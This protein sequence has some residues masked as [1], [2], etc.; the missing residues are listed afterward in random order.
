[1]SSPTESAA[2][3]PNIGKPASNKSQIIRGKKRAHYQEKDINAILDSSFLCHVGFV[4]EG[5][6][7]VIPTAYVRR[8]KAIYLHGHLQN[9]M[10]AALLDGQTACITVTLIDGMVLARS[11]IHH[12]VNF[13]SAVVY[14]KGVVVD[15][16]EKISALDALIDH[17]VPGRSADLRPHTAQELN[18]TLVIKF[19]IEEASAKIRTGPPADSEKDLELDTWAGVLKLKTQVE[20]IENCPELKAAIPIPQ[21]IK[22]FSHSK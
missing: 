8:G 5:Q 6:A 3:N 9:Q 19:I 10:M 17:Y 21:Y 15:G 7:R 14:G 12:S 22:S 20:D 1:M 13:R 11:A 4:V 18:A 16:E 2:V